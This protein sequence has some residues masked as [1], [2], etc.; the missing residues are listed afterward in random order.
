[1]TIPLGWL[2]GIFCALTG[3]ALHGGQ[4]LVL[5][6]PYE[7]LIIVGLAVGYLIASNNVRSLKQTMRAVP[8][9]FR[10]VAINKRLY[11]DLLCLL[12]EILNN[13]RR[14]GLMSLEADI[15]DPGS[16]ALFAKYPTIMKDHHLVEFLTDYM[17]MML[18]GALNVMQIENLMEQE[19]DV[20]HQV[21]NAPVVVV[22]RMADALP[23][24]GIIAAVMGVVNTMGSIGLPPEE[25]GK[26]IGA[27]LVGTFLGILLAYSFVGPVASVMEQNNEAEFKALLCVK[28]VLLAHMNGCTPQTSVEFGR[29]ILYS[30]LRPNFQ[31]MDDETKVAKA[32]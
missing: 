20:H 32:K 15:E 19:L 2:I 14:D 27:A 30:D 12:F 23:A 1:M 24:F 7:V 25:L 17:R 11:L 13:I 16:S 10:G 22:Q 21:A 28:S 6:Q 5:W 9:A 18:G 4:I 29:K 31:E 3:Y 8:A 26:L